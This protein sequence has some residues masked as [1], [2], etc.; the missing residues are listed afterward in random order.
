MGYSGVVKSE[1]LSSE[2]GQEVPTSKPQSM[3][4][5][6][7]SPNLVCRHE[8]HPLCRNGVDKRDERHGKKRKK[9]AIP[10]TPPPTPPRHHDSPPAIIT[11][12]SAGAAGI[13]RLTNGRRKKK[14]NPVPGSQRPG[15]GVL[16]LV[17]STVS[18]I[19]GVGTCGLIHRN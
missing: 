5:N 1:V 8:T 17:L 19:C 6:K 2:E 12:P 4:C 10:P 13:L 3:P 15:I 9:V 14:K 16:Q 7:Q 18:Y 11:I